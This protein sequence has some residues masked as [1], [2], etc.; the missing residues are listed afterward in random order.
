MP[1][2]RCPFDHPPTMNCC[3]ECRGAKMPFILPIRRPPT[4]AHHVAAVRQMHAAGLSKAAIA[5]Q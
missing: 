4:V 3:V 5:R 2:L 1:C